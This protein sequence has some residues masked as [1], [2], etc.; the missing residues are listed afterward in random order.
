MMS[1]LLDVIKLGRYVMHEWHSKATQVKVM[2]NSV[3]LPL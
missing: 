3:R 2:E 1:C